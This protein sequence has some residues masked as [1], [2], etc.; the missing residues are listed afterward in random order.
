MRT[1]PPPWGGFSEMEAAVFRDEG[2][3][4]AKALLVNRKALLVDR[5]ALL[6]DRKALLGDGAGEGAV[7]RD[8]PPLRQPSPQA[9]GRTPDL[10][11]PPPLPPHGPP[12][13]GA[14]GPASLGGAVCAGV[15]VNATAGCRG[16]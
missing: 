5:K 11:G 10:G 2:V 1:G 14:A 6:L 7:R 12:G 13:D 16:Y 8:Q 15:K 3:H 9:R 4:A